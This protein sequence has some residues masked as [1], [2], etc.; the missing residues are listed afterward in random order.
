MT[1]ATG[2]TCPS[3][4]AMP[5]LGSPTTDIVLPTAHPRILLSFIVLNSVVVLPA[6]VSQQPRSL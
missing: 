2:T 1:G 5:Y 3:L 4:P 6:T